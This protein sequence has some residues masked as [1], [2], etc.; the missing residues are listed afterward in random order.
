MKEG[1]KAKFTASWKK[2]FKSDELPI[3]FWYADDS[4]AELAIPSKEYRC[5]ISFYKR[6]FAGE[7]LKFSDASIGCFGGKRY[8]GF[9]D[10]IRPNF[11]YFLSC[12]IPGKMEGERYKKSPELVKSIMAKAKPFKA[13]KKYLV[14]KRWDKVGA[15]EE[16]EGVIFFSKAVELSGL[17][18]LA[19]FDEDRDD[20][21]IAPFG[22]GCASTIYY[23]YRENQTDNPRCILGMF[24]ISERP[25]IDPDR[26]AFMAPMKKFERMINNMDESFLITGSWEKARP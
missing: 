2:Y 7:S 10:S 20:G 12:G 21:V 3:A 15:G 18:T 26:I 13:P 14:L 8:A 4:D 24:D 9:S 16:P 19:S 17:F 6:V 11:E 1:L 22:A 25:F 23:P 5:L